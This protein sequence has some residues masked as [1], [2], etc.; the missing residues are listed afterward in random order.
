[1]NRAP[2]KNGVATN[3]IFDAYIAP[4]VHGKEKTMGFTIFRTTATAAICLLLAALFVFP[5][6]CLKR[7]ADEAEAHLENAQDA[8]L[9]HDLDTAETECAALAAL[10]DERMPALERFLSHA[11]VDALD[12]SFRIAHAAVRVGEAGAAFEALAEASSIL[13][14]LKGIELFSPNSLL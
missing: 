7:F 2:Q 14:R 11:G 3:R 8:L 9:M 10:I 6:L 1:M 13:E 4:S 5:S 12:A